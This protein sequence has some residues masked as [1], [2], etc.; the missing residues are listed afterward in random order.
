MEV[1]R[2]GWR[3]KG[4]RLLSECN[5]STYT[6]RARFSSRCQ[7]CTGSEKRIAAGA[8]TKCEEQVEVKLEV[9]VQVEGLRGAKVC[10]GPPAR[11]PGQHR[12]AAAEPG[13]WWRRRRRRRDSGGREGRQ[14][15][16]PVEPGEL[17]ESRRIAAL[18]GGRL[19]GL[20]RSGR[21]RAERPSRRNIVTKNSP[22][23]RRTERRDRLRSERT[24]EVCWLSRTCPRI[25]Y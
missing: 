10:S 1:G 22:R 7:K 8:A 25:Y 4:A 17:R 18:K 12:A 16:Y 15:R 24:A 23:R 6:P 5:R 19:S 9:P 21:T 11:F 2:W 20:H 13:W 14:T 3:S